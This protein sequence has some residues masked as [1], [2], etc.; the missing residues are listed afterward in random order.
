MT[1]IQLQDVTVE[2]PTRTQGRSLVVKALDGVSLTVRHGEVMGVIGPTGCG[3]S[4]LLRTVAG[5]LQPQSG[6]ILFDGQDLSTVSP[7]ERGV[8]MVFQDYALYPHYSVLDN[9]AFYFKLRRRQA[10]VPARV[11]EAARILGVDLQVLLGR[12][13]GNLSMGQRQQVAVARC[14]VRDPKV[15]LM[16]EPFANIDAAQRQHARVQLK[17]LL[18]H[19]R[20]T[21]LYV[22]HDQQEAAA[23]CTR[24]AVMER[25]QVRQVDTYAHLLT[26]PR[27]LVV[28]EFVS[29]A[30]AQSVAGACLE[31]HFVCPD[32]SVPL[33]PAVLVRT[34]PGQALVLRVPPAAVSLAEVGVEVVVELVEPLL[35]QRRKR[36]TCQ[37]SQVTLAVE[38]PQDLPAQAGDRVRLAI[39]PQQVQVFDAKTGV[40]LA[41]AAPRA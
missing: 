6:R 2:L 39:D 7:R 36:L 18:D 27:E 35:M 34:Q 40:N 9:L 17:R 10:E 12:M 22:T 41:L 3:K 14:L 25:G 29:V 1:L 24:I 19:F 32:F 28:A 26:W 11:Q 4:T 33:L 38:A 21:T 8:G 16:D 30:G 15:F 13:P 20:V 37:A 5:L 23:L 31:G